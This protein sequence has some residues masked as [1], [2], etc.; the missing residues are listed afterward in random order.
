MEQAKITTE[1]FRKVIEKICS[2]DTSADPEHWLA[3]NPTWGHCAV[4]SLLSQDQ[5]GG[6]L[7]RQSLDGIA[8]LEY[9]RSHYSNRL[10]DGTEADYTLGQFQGKLPA[11]LSKEE[12]P[13]ER[14][15]SYP[16]TQKRYQLLKNRFEAELLKI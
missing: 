3:E 6:A 8:G 10:P 15:L 4:V 5:F 12:R 14:V 16:D 1:E 11:D 2:R 9:L 13:R 7:I